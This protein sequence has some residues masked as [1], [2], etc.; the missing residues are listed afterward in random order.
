VLIAEQK[1]PVQVAEVDRVQVYNVNLAKAREHKILEQF[2][3]D[4]AS[5]HHQYARL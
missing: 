1:L 3:A 2:A 5:A 4:A